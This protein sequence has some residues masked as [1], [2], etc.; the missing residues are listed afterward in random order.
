MSLS[1]VVKQGRYDLVEALS[2]Y[3]LY[4]IEEFIRYIQL[5]G[6]INL[7]DQRVCASVDAE[8]EQN[9]DFYDANNTKGSLPSGMMVSSKRK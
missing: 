5:S 1:D 2:S 7:L 8:T 9:P 4:K 6:G 3:V